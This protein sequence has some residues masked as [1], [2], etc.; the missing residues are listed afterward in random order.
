DRDQIKAAAAGRCDIAIAN[1][2]YYAQMLGS[3]DK[4][5]IGAANAVALFWP[6]QDDRG[7]HIN[8]SGVGLTAAAKNRENAIQLMEFLVSD[9]TQQW[10]ATINHEY[11]A[12]HG[13][14]P[15]DALTTW[16]EFKSDTL[17]LSR[18]G[19]LNADAV[20]LMDRAGW[21]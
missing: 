5:Q 2:Y 18:L 13:I 9:E 17:N 1:T 21:R 3:G 16:G 14:N 15:S 8:I 12:V 20:R 19:E 7:T 6:N 11:P 4:S 10:Y